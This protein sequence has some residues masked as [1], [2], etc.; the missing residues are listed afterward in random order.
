MSTLLGALLDRSPAQRYAHHLQVIVAE[1]W[2]DAAGGQRRCPAVADS[3]AAELPASN[4]GHFAT[5]QPLRARVIGS[6]LKL[7]AIRCLASWASRRSCAV[8][9]SRTFLLA[10]AAARSREFAICSALGAGRRRIVR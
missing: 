5:A 8:R 3:L 10:R 6:E 2:R 9:T 1:T 7:T 4:K